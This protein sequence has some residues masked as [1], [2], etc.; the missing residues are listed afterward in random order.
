M[1]EPILLLLWAFLN[2]GVFLGFYY[3]TVYCWRRIRKQI[4]NLLLYF[5]KNLL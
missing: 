1:F 4:V 3:L 5:R 2:I